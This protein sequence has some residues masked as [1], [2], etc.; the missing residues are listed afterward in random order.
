MGIRLLVFFV[1][2][3]GLRSVG[4]RVLVL[5]GWSLGLLAGVPPNGGFEDDVISRWL[6]PVKN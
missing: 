2:S 5:L 3:L 1:W 6:V 4:I